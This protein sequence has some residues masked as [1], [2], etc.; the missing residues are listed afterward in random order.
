MGTLIGKKQYSVFEYACMSVI[1][2]VYGLCLLNLAFDGYT[3]AC[4]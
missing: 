2:E 3:N 1:G 4:R